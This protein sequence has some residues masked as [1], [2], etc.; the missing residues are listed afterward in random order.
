[1]PTDEMYL[2]WICLQVSH[3]LALGTVS[4]AFSAPSSRV[5]A[6]SLLAV[7]YPQI[8]HAMRLWTAI[9]DRVFERAFNRTNTFDAESVKAVILEYT[10]F[11]KKLP[12]HSAFVHFLPIHSKQ[13]IMYGNST[14]HCKAVLASHMAD[15]HAQPPKGSRTS[16]GNVSLA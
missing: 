12:Q 10:K 15:V 5:P 16:P 14:M 13:P 1:M 9:I 4:R 8:P 2:Q 6:V 7:K 3:L 11:P